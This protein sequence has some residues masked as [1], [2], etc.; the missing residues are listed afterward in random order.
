[1]LFYG[2][3]G[4]GKTTAI[5]ALCRK[6]YNTKSPNLS[7]P[8]VIE[9]NASDE[10]GIKTI[11]ES[12]KQFASTTLDGKL[13]L[14]ILDEAD[15]MSRDAQNALR[16]VIEDFSTNCRFCLIANYANKIIPAIQSRCCKF[17]FGPITKSND[18]IIK[19]VKEICEKENINFTEDG[20][21]TLI[22]V[23][24][25]DARKLVNDIEGVYKA[26]GKITKE[27]VLLLSNTVDLSVYELLF[28]DLLRN[29]LV[30]MVQ[31]IHSAMKENSLECSVLV[32]NLG[33]LVKES[34]LENKLMILNE[35]SDL[36][37]RVLNGGSQNV[38]SMAIAGI[39]FK[40]RS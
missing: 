19:R 39:L 6:I 30:K 11:R 2:P 20:L 12:V 29:N 3:P 24:N 21:K 33:E 4:T 22:K 7:I 31:L 37:K 5:R 10:R 38:Q 32:N 35:F 23:S 36:E 40:Y 17:R 8:N 16:R 27:N 1:M 13:K 14:V 34:E 15:S 25:G 28:Y 26:Y 18:Q 9:L